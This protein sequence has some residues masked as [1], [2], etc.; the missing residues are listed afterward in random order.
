MLAKASQ[1]G[2]GLIRLQQGLENVERSFAA[3]NPRF[4]NSQRTTLGSSAD[5]L[6]VQTASIGRAEGDIRWLV[7]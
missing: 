1:V 2:E 5:L 3:K 6:P 4:R 7:L